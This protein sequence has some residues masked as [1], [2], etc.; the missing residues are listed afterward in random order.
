MTTYV[1]RS[2]LRDRNAPGNITERMLSWPE[3]AVSASRRFPGEP[4]EFT[5]KSDILKAKRER[6]EQSL[7][8]KREIGRVERRALY[9]WVFWCPGI[10]GFAF[11]GWWTYLVGIGGKRY[12]GHGVKGNVAGE[13]MDKVMELFPVANP[14]PL[15]GPVDLHD[16]K[17]LFATQY[18]H[19]LWCGKP[20]G[21]A[22]VWAMVEGERVLTIE[23]P[24]CS[25]GE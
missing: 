23:R 25:A 8:N 22:A 20:Q 18:Q 5:Y 4:W 9:V 12:H 14:L 3:D 7:R 24:V 19:G 15:F 16:W 6:M 11:R 2:R 13:L 21:K 17:P 1:T 10:G